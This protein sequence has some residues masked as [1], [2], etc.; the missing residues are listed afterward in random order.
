MNPYW[1]KLSKRKLKLA[2]LASV[3]AGLVG[4]AALSSGQVLDTQAGLSIF[5][6]SPK[7]ECIE[8]FDDPDYVDFVAV[9]T[10][11]NIH[12]PNPFDVQVMTKLLELDFGPSD[13]SSPVGPIVASG[14]VIPPDWGFNVDC[15]DITGAEF[16]CIG[17]PP[18]TQEGFVIIETLFPLD[19]VVLYD[20]DSGSRN[21]QTGEPTAGGV[22]F[23]YE[24]V[25]PTIVPGPFSP[26]GCAWP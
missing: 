12:N 5:V 21:F 13:P 26:P 17:A 15:G 10:E 20:K 14:T 18:P 24:R 7:Y 3:A 6:Y 11:I 16:A 23:E 9:E 4:T 8:Y 2:I 1:E 19:V 22:D 25:A